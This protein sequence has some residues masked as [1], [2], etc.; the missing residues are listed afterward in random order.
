MRRLEDSQLISVA[1]DI[2][3]LRE[4]WADGASDADLRRGSALL[5]R[6]LI[7]G[8][9]GMLMAVWH[10]LGL[11]DQ[12]RVIAPS[13]PLQ[14]L[15]A[16]AKVD[17]AA[18]GGAT[19]EGGTMAGFRQTTERIAAEFSPDGCEQLL[20]EYVGAPSVIIRGEQVTRRELVKYFAHHL[21]GVHMSSKVLKQEQDMV[22]RIRR[23]ETL[24]IYSHMLGK[25]LLHF[26]L[27][28]IGQAIGRA[29]DFKKMSAVIRERIGS[30]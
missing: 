26:E 13:L 22:R 14:I 16:G 3:Y 21:G 1:E 10:R 25:D 7:D 18:A 2:E 11:L 9:N 12:P 4:K 24:Q 15:A 20:L 23:I 5:R 28:A 6:F 17:L 30:I 27:L 29:D 8:G 19:V